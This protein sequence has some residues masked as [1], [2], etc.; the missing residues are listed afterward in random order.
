MTKPAS[1]KERSLAIRIA[2][3]ATESEK[4]AL[5]SWIEGMIELRDSNESA[6]TKVKK[7]IE[8]TAA[9]GALLRL[10]ELVG[11]ELTPAALTELM[12]GLTEINN[13]SLPN[14]QKLE[15]PE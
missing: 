7:S 3:T 9:S 12:A 14:T 13:S 8:M 10:I 2:S 6:M 4:I 1:E 11:R 15:A 5:K